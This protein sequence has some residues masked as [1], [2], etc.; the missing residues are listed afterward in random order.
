M[1]PK[2]IARLLIRIG[3]L[4][5]PKISVSF[6]ARAAFVS[7]APTALSFRSKVP[8]ARR[9]CCIS[10]L[11]SRL[12]E[13]D[14]TRSS[15][16]GALSSPPAI[17][18]DPA[19]ASPPNGGILANVSRPVQVKPEILLSSLRNRGDDGV[20]GVATSASRLRPMPSP[21][22]LVL[23]RRLS[24][25]VSTEGVWIT[26]D[27]KEPLAVVQLIVEENLLNGD[28]TGDK[29]G[30]GNMGSRR[31]L[32]TFKGRVSV[33]S[34][35]NHQPAKENS[36]EEE[37]DSAM[38]AM[39]EATKSVVSEA[40]RILLEDIS[41][42]NITGGDCGDN[43]KSSPYSRETSPNFR[44]SLMFP[45]MDR[46]LLEPVRTV[47]SPYSRLDS[48]TADPPVRTFRSAWLTECML[49]TY[50]GLQRNE[51][52]I[53]RELPPGCIIRALNREDAELVN[54]RWEYRS[55]DSIHLVRRLIDISASNEDNNAGKGGCIGMEVDG[56]L[57]AWVLRYLDGA[58]GMIWTEESYR[59][60]GFASMLLSAV[61]AGC[62]SRIPKEEFLFAFVVDGN[63]ASCAMFERL[64]WNKEAS[65]DWV[66]FASFDERQN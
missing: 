54:S 45:G 52:P 28:E 37:C 4:L 36:D 60:R 62:A 55:D 40:I 46:R 47:L 16:G 31:K 43:D 34:F 13:S 57:V 19:S 63:A 48:S 21:W 58:V 30:R 11:R 22:S 35:L 24:S 32:K 3:F 6:S 1:E 29:G 44:L 18:M 9:R 51:T 59:Q 27:R 33:Y 56:E 64:G 8:S 2:I 50:R 15:V 17:S 66:G 53:A 7:V 38:L 26:D 61:M 41:P 5:L 10:R 39:E 20:V 42:N 12:G 14:D 23:R 65:A 25:P 49:Y